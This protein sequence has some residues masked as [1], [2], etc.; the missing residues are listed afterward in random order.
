MAP[1][2]TST[3]TTNSARRATR[4]LRKTKSAA[5]TPPIPA[6]RLAALRMPGRSLPLPLPRTYSMPPLPSLAPSYH[7]PAA[8]GF[9]NNTNIAVSSL[10]T[11]ID[12]SDGEPET[13]TDV[14]ARGASG[15]DLRSLFSFSRGVGKQTF[16]DP[17]YAVREAGHSQ[18]RIGDVMGEG[19]FSNA[20]GERVINDESIQAKSEPA[21]SPNPGS[22]GS[23]AVTEEAGERLAGAL[24]A[25]PSPPPSAVSAH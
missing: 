11:A 14:E 23:R 12:E 7:S 21:S 8:A 17:A 9:M 24:S 1:Q 19:S 6:A 10:R 25:A 16:R 4:A 3:K 15:Y 13:D 2:R 5:S 22:S 20:R 18:E